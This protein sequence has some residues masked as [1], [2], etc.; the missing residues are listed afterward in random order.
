MNLTPDL[1]DAMFT[2]HGIPGPWAPLP[3][4]GIA[5]HIFSTP[6]VVLRVATDHP[7]GVSDARTESVAAPVA[8]AAGIPTPRLIAF[9]DSRALVDRPFS[10]WE[11]VQGE[12]LGLLSLGLRQQSEVWRQVGRQLFRLHHRVRECADPNGYLDT[13]GRELDLLPLLNRLAD[14]GRLDAATA[15]GIAWLIGE[16]APHMAAGRDVRFL[17]NDIHDMNVMCSPAG[18]LL[19]IIDWGDAGWG[20]PTLEFA[21]IP[22]ESIPDTRAGYESEAPGALGVFPEARFIWDKLAAVLEVAWDDCSQSIPLDAFR[23]FLRQGVR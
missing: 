16:L 18:E 8:H 11:R 14:A 22:L 2:A 12:T 5:N 9:D 20:D 23:R 6:D 7:E 3:A 17:H 1:V 15:K 19:A 4:T 10:L 13:P 21:W